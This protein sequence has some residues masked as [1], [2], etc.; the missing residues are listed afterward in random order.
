MIVRNEEAN[1]ADCLKSAAGVADDVVV[2]DTGST[3]ATREIAG[4][5][6]AR[7]I[8]FPW[9][10]DFA[11]ARNESLRHAAG[12]WI[13]WLDADDRL[14][15]ENRRRLR[16]LVD[17]LREENIA[18]VMKCLCLSAPGEQGETVVDH[19]RL[20]RNHPEIRWRYRVHEQI[21]PSIRRLGG[22]VRWSDVVIRHVGYQDPALRRRKLERDLRLLHRE[23]QDSPDDPF[24]LF[25][26]GSVYQ[27]MERF[28][29]ALTMLS[30]SLDRSSPN[31][32]IVRKLYALIA[33]AHRRMGRGAGALAACEAGRNLF[34][35]D[36]ELLFQEALARRDHRDLAGAEVCLRRLLQS[37]E[38]DHFSSIDA[39]LGGYKARHNLAVV[40]TEQARD[41]E[42]EDQ[43]RAAFAERPDFAPAW[44]GL[45]GLFLRQERWSDVEWLAGQVE[46]RA[47]GDGDAVVIRARAH[48][49]RREYRQARRLLEDVTAHTPLAL[50]PL[51]LL[52]HVL[53][54]E[55]ADR[56]SAEA[57][58][59]NILVLDPANTEAMHNLSV[60]LG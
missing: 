8:E 60:L 50:R 46:I 32:S 51:V 23:H 21:L 42:A 38:G 11:A 19:V 22:E 36:P 6:G 18:Y 29:E 43:W 17:G 16:A 41:A 14:D 59:R 39:G 53:L 15:E 34:P 2:V 25:N 27:E 52:S 57:K 35:D 3:D 24:T 49:A 26:L 33:Q 5:L 7:V 47:P 58:L 31:D 12:D 20:F 55:N 37:R 1:I 28:E 45:E 9:V 54:Q 40:L 13:L 48:L 30:R 44:R 4:R 56:P 10:D